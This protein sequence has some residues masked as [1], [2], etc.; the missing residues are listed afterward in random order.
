M[1][2]TDQIFRIMWD[3]FDA[4]NQGDSLRSAAEKIYAL[5]EPDHS[6][7]VAAA[8]LENEITDSLVSL[9]AATVLATLVEEEGGGRTNIDISPASMDH[10]TKHW[11]MEVT[12]NGLVRTVKIKMREDS[13]LHDA[14]EWSKDSNRH[15][16]VDV[17]ETTFAPPYAGAIGLTLQPQAE[18]HEYNRPQWVVACNALDGSKVLY[19]CFD[20]RDAE[21]ELRSWDRDRVLA[22]NAHIENRWCMHPEC[23]S[24]GCSHDVSK[25]DEVSSGD[26]AVDTPLS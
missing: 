10:M 1:L 4:N 5:I 14:A 24:T 22:S 12:S 2:S 26:S 21:R 20:R 16:L 23:P 17:A 6:G 15:G 9:V 7:P 19:R 3:E 18:P 8:M 25:R 13:T 11:E